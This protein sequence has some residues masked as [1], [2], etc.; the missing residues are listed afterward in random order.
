MLSQEQV[1][2]ITYLEAE[3]FRLGGHFNEVIRGI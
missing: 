3:S 1:Q 2:R